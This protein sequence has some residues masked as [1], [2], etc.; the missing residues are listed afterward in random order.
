MSTPLPCLLGSLEAR[1]RG[2]V[3]P[4]SWHDSECSTCV[5]LEGARRCPRWNCI[6]IL[7]V[8]WCGHLLQISVILQAKEGRQHVF[9]VG[10]GA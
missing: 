4:W 5:D 2:V 1:S 10:T 7:V 8:A 6:D 3:G 9:R